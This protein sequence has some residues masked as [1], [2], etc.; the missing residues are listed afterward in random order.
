MHLGMSRRAGAFPTKPGTYCTTIFFEEEHMNQVGPG[1]FKKLD[2]GLNV[3]VTHGILHYLSR[4]I[5]G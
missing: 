2:E 4:K 5:L 3:P 1:G